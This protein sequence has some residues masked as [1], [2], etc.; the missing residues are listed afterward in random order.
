MLKCPTLEK[1]ILLGKVESRRKTE[2]LN[3][4]WIEQGFLGDDILEIANSYGHCKLE[5]T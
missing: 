5:V 3:M 4:R 2:R 1:V